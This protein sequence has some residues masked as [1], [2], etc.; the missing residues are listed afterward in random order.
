MPTSLTAAQRTP[1]AD[2]VNFTVGFATAARFLDAWLADGSARDSHYLN[3]SSVLAT[4]WQ[5]DAPDLRRRGESGVSSHCLQTDVASDA[6]PN[7]GLTANPHSCTQSDVAGPA[8][9]PYNLPAFPVIFVANPAQFPAHALL[10][11]KS[12]SHQARR[13]LAGDRCGRAL[14]G[15]RAT[16]AARSQQSGGRDGIRR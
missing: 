11:V 7:P 8:P 15:M 14:P 13:H 16:P 5:N 12:I 6:A 4:G 2:R 9:R 3:L 1:A 10:T